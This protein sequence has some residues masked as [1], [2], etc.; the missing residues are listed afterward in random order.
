MKAAVLHE[1]G[2]PPELDEFD[3]PVEGGG[4]VVAEV[5]AAGVNHLDLLKTSGRFYTEPPPIP[6]VVGSDG[7]GRLADGRR[8]FF[9]A[10]AEPYGTM[11]ERT[12]VSPDELLDVAE[13]VED[14]VAAALGNSG[15]A[16]WLA[17]EWRAGLE[18]GET[19]LVLGAT[20]AVGNVAVQAASLLGAGR[21]VAAA[22]GGARLERLLER[23]ADAV[24]DLDGEEDLA[25]ALTEATKGGAQ[26]TVDP[27]WGEPAVAAMKGAT[28][29]ARHIQVGH[30][31]APT[32]ELPAMV[33]RSALL[34]LL[35]FVLFRVPINVRRG[36]YRK[37]TELAARGELEVDLE[38]VPLSEVDRAWE[39]QQEGPDAKLVIV[40]DD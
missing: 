3:E 12:L 33:V 31:A 11:A 36:A 8:V 14:E 13:G 27:L 35:G 21:V 34:E 7:V 20:G 40:P 9:D 16:A 22:R 2:E 6:S 39:R 30:M 38:R 15:L 29:D 19:V 5:A 26:V 17:L 28:L 4:N 37:L 32:V 25:A 1:H 18:P 10:P 24:V 23:G